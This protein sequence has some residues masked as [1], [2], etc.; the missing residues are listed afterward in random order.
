MA[1]L[2]VF[3][4]FNFRQYLGKGI[5]ALRPTCCY[6]NL[7]YLYVCLQ[8]LYQMLI[9]LKSCVFAGKRTQSDSGVGGLFSSPMSSSCLLSLLPQ[10]NS[11]TA[12]VRPPYAREAPRAVDSS[13]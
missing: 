3:F 7:T 9:V 13:Q 4:F 1:K 12:L 6:L 5:E 2:M 8:P 11:C 10:Q